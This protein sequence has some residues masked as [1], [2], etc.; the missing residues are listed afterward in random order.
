MPRGKQDKSQSEGAKQRL[1]PRRADAKDEWGGFVPCDVPSSDRPIFEAWYAGDDTH[2]WNALG[3][4]MFS[5]LK[6]SLTFDKANDCYIASLSGRPDAQG[7]REW[8]AVLTARSNDLNSAVALL[9][10]KHDN[11]LARDWWAAMNAPKQSRMQF[12]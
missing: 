8:N 5:G 6:F 1:Q 12:G 2:V 7:L 10:Y 4:A 3:E 11:L 9:I